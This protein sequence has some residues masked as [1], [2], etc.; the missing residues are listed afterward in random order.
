MDPDF[1]DL[2]SRATA[3]MAAGYGTAARLRAARL[4]AL[5]QVPGLLAG[6]VDLIWSFHNTTAGNAVL[7]A[8]RLTVEAAWTVQN[9]LCLL[10]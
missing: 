4:E 2:E 7:L 5:S 9:R 6:D 1:P 10:I 8:Q 3:L